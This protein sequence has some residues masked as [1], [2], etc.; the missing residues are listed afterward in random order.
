[1]LTFLSQHFQF[2]LKVYLEMAREA[3]GAI[4]TQPQIQNVTCLLGLAQAKVKAVLLG[5]RF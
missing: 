1:M 2:N 3:Y 4:V 5:V